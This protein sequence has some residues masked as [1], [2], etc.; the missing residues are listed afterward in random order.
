MDLNSQWENFANFGT[1]EL[2]STHNQDKEKKTPKC[3][4]I[5]I[6]TK[7]KIAYLNTS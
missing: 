1:F 2:E 5:Y 4:E 7:T 3:S 6:S